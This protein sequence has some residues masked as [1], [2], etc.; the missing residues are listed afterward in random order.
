MTRTLLI[1]F[2]AASIL[3]LVAFA[4][5]A[6]L[7]GA[8]IRRN[9]F[10]WV[11]DE[12][13][14]RV[15]VRRSTT[16]EIDN[17]PEIS[18]TVAWTGGGTLSLELPADVTYVQG[19]AANVVISGPQSAVD[20]VQVDGGRIRMRDGSERAVVRWDANGIEGWSDSE[21]LRIVVTAPSVNRFEIEGSSDLTIQDYDQTA[22]AV[23]ISGSGDVRASGRAD[24]LD[25][26]VS[27]SGDVDLS[28]VT[29]TDATID[30]TGSGDVTAGPTGEAD[31]TLTGSGDVDLTRRPT[32]LRQ[33]T[34]GSGDV[35]E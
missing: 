15:S 31:I 27:G 12:S 29:A 16:L 35:E 13:N 8:D 22:L 32:Q 7:G 1:I 4:G 2:G 3:C 11:F 21:R 9:G 23:D 33:N 10:T 14:D 30:V 25:V 5:A 28:D 6:A 34:S 24:R 17:G 26:D 20:R 19:D 18:R